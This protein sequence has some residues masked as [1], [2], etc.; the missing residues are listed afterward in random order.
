MRNGEIKDYKGK[1]IRKVS[2]TEWQVGGFF[3]TFQTYDEAKEA[4]DAA[5]AED[6]SLRESEQYVKDFCG[7]WL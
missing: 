3:W 1:V 7:G 2:G 4:I 5:E 6:R